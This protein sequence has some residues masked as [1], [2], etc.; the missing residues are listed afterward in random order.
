MTKETV[1]NCHALNGH[2]TVKILLKMKRAIESQS[3]KK[4]Q[5][6]GQQYVLNESIMLNN[7]N[8]CC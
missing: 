7:I 4:P 8:Q 1:T 3:L 6:R 2:Y 5:K